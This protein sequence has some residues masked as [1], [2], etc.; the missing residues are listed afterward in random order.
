MDSLVSR[1]QEKLA[2]FRIKELKD[3]LGQIGIVKQGKKQVLFGACG[4]NNSSALCM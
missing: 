4:Q 2:T 1:Y 3:V